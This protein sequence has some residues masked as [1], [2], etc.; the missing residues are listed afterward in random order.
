MVSWAERATTELNATAE[1]ARRGP[2]AATELTPQE[3]TVARLVAEGATNKNVAE[4]L[5][6]SRKTVESHLHKVYTKMGISSRTQ[7]ADALP[8][9]N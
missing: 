2:D 7:L 8:P 3:L 9:E 6:L 4:Q 5:F 1:R